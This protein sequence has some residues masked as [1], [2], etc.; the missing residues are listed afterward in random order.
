M[1]VK[2]IVK[3]KAKNARHDGDGST[4]AEEYPVTYACPCTP[5]ALAGWA[6][7]GF[8]KGPSSLYNEPVRNLALVS[9]VVYCRKNT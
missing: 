9:C 4:I 6:S 3:P 1:V 8:Y 5:R 7:M 2:M